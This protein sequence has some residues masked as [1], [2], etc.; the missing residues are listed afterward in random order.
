MTKT[1]PTM[2]EIFPNLKTPRQTKN[3]R[4]SLK[5]DTASDLAKRTVWFND[6][7]LAGYHTVNGK[8]LLC[9]FDRYDAAI[10]SADSTRAASKGAA[11]MSGL[12]SDLY[13]LF[14]REDEYGG[15]PRIGQDVTVD[16][17]KL[18]VT[19]SVLYDGVHEITLKAGA[20]R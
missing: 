9:V 11:V 5:G 19:G 12:Q 17:R 15:T 2:E 8:K 10:A 3:P 1:Y 18:Y 4:K 7:E 16:G 20:V 13:L 6:L 14:I